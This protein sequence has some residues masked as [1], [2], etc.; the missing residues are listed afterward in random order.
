MKSVLQIINEEIRLWEY[1]NQQVHSIQDLGKFMQHMGYDNR[2]SDI[3]TKMLLTAYRKSGDQ[4][5]VDKYLQMTGTQIYPISGGR[6]V[7]GNEPTGGGEPQLEQDITKESVD[8][9]HGSPHD[10]DSFSIDHMGSGEG[11]QSF[12]WGLYFSDLE[13]IANHY[14]KTKHNMDFLANYVYGT[15]SY[16]VEDLKSLEAKTNEQLIAIINKVH[17]KY[18]KNIKK[19]N[20]RNRAFIDD[21][22]EK[23][24]ITRDYLIREVQSTNPSIKYHVTLHKGK[25]P[26]Q[27]DY[28]L[29]NDALNNAQKQK[30]SNQGQR[31]GIETGIYSDEVG[32]FIYKK[33]TNILGGKKEASLFLLRAGIDGIKYPAES[34]ANGTTADTARG[35]NYVVFDPQA[36]SINKKSVNENTDEGVG[37]KY[38]ERK[39]NIPDQDKLMHRQTS[40]AIQKPDMGQP[41]GNTTSEYND[42]LLSPV[43]LNPA[44]LKNFEKD[45]RAVSDLQGNLYVAQ[46]DGNF[47]HAGFNS[48]IK[49][50]ANNNGK[51]ITWVRLGNTNRFAY[52]DSFMA[53]AQQPKYREDIENRLNTLAG[54]HQHIEFIPKFYYFADEDN[55]NEEQKS[56]VSNAQKIADNLVRSEYWDRVEKNNPSEYK[57]PIV[58]N[59][60]VGL[61]DQAFR[62]DADLYIGRDDKGIGN[63]KERVLLNIESGELKYAPDA[64]IRIVNNQPLLSF[65]DGRHRFAVLRD[66]GVKTI[67]ITFPQESSDKIHLLQR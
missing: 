58:A 57:K 67:N 30:I 43:Y 25:T 46:I 47:V 54:K 37:D 42:S 55:L 36:V 20:A 45:I 1:E 15:L 23:Q 13:D 44:S 49:G 48:V 6:Y 40:A 16:S 32:G 60:D 63:R 31:E 66:L 8:A 52:S 34:I 18:V 61:A 41:V 4:G 2:M 38:A 64:S 27:Y 17:D 51:F 62:R 35:F 26:D 56:D 5:V 50:D 7:F 53:Y 65:A 33:L 3:M 22:V 10:F 11:A 14:S 19:Q 39:W 59:V 12:G 24:D 29:W 21:E 28:M 9:W